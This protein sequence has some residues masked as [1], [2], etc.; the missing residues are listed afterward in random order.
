MR[1]ALAHLLERANGR[2]TVAIL[3]EMAELGADAPGYHEQVGREANR[4]DV[5]LGVGELARH[6]EP[7]EWVPTA[8]EAVEVAR[9]L[10]RPGDAIL[11][12]GS[13]AVGLEAVADAIREAGE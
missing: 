6:Y 13:R 3:G 5:V 1:A 12:K 4:V 9:G 10:V 11:V 8:G 7:D 2:R